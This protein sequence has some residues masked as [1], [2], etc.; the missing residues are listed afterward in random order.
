VAA[1]SAGSPRGPSTTARTANPQFVCD[2]DLFYYLNEGT[3][4]WDNVEA[5]TGISAY[6]NLV[7]SKKEL[8]Q[9]NVDALKEALGWDGMSFASLSSGDWSQTDVQVTLEEEEYEGKVQIKVKYI[10][11]R[12][13]E[14]RGIQADPQAI[15]A[16]DQQFGAMLRAL[17]PNP[18]AA[19]PG[20]PHR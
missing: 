6:F 18:R 20:P 14:P 16:A 7:T 1:T 5:G 15:A 13:W 2:I 4:N 8:N 12:D 17:G 9:F 10:N 3:K 19:K 11:P